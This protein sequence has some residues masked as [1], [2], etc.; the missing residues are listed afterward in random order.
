MKLAVFRLVFLQYLVT[1][2]DAQIYTKNTLTT[3]KR[4]LYI[5]RGNTVG[6]YIRRNKKKMSVFV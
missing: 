3:L 2:L 6:Q 4:L 5:E 1:Y